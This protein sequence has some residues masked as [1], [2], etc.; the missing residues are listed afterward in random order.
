MIPVK[1]RTLLLFSLL[2]IASHL[3]RSIWGVGLDIRG[4]FPPASTAVMTAEILLLQEKDNERPA[5]A[6]PPSNPWVEE[7]MSE[8]LDARNRTRHEFIQEALLRSKSRPYGHRPVF[9]KRHPAL[10]GIPNEYLPKP[11]WENLLLPDYSVVGFAKA[12]T[13]QLFR[14]LTG[15]ATKIKPYYPGRKGK[16]NLNRARKLLSQHSCFSTGLVRELGERRKTHVHASRDTCASAKDRV[17]EVQCIAGG[18]GFW[19]VD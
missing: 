17:K 3:F 7:E 10:A 2:H 13:S 19:P 4:M 15:N 16:D 6:S 1:A 9:V 11:E 5:A 18:S 12:G 8:L 14:I